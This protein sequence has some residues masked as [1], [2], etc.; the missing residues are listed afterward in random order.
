MIETTLSTIVMIYLLLT[1]GLLLGLWAVR[2][3]Q[4]RKI[5][6][7]CVEEHIACCEYCH[8][9]YL[10]KIASSLSRCPQCKS[11]NREPGK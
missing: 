5:K 10:K 4:R 11:F 7:L 1:L 8:Y 9:S 3:Y 6:F 2:H